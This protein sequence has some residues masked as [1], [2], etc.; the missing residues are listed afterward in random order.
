MHWRCTRKKEILPQNS[1]RI[2]RCHVNSNTL[3]FLQ[4]NSPRQAP[5]WCTVLSTEVSNVR[6][7]WHAARSQQ[8]ASQCNGVLVQLPAWHHRNY[9]CSFSAMDILWWIR[10]NRT[11]STWIQLSFLQNIKFS[12]EIPLYSDVQMQSAEQPIVSRYRTL[13]IHEPEACLDHKLQDSRK[14]D[15]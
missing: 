6:A 15:I 9:S 7:P 11:W 5:L 4:A 12:T 13:T 10:R 1:Y 8:A 2:I 3:L 14:T